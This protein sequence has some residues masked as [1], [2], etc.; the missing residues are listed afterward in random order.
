MQY[1]Y[2][3]TGNAN[4]A[5]IYGATFIENNPGWATIDVDPD[6]LYQHVLIGDSTT[7]TITIHN[8]GDTDLQ[9][10]IAAS[11]SQRIASD[12][13]IYLTTADQGPNISLE[14]GPGVQDP[15]YELNLERL[16]SRPS[17][18]DGDL[19]VLLM[20]NNTSNN[21]YFAGQIEPYVENMDFASWDIDQTPELTYLQ[22]FDVILLQENGLTGNSAN[23]GDI[24]AEYV[25][26]GGN[27]ILS[28]FYWQDRTD[29][30]FGTQGWGELELY[31]PLYGDACDYA[32]QDLGT[33]LDHPMTEGIDE[34]NCYYRGGPTILRDDATAVAWWSDGDP[35][36]AYNQPGGVI[37][38]ITIFP[39]HGVYSSFSGDFYELF[40]N[41]IYWTANASP[42]WL[43]TDIVSGTVAPGA[44][45]DI[46]VSL[47]ASELDTGY[48]TAQLVLN[49]NDPIDPSVLIPV[50]LEVYML[51]PDIA[52]A[53]DSLSEELYIGDSSVQTLMIYN[54]GEADLDWNA[55]TLFLELPTRSPRY[56]LV[57]YS[58]N[59]KI[60]NELHSIQNRV[61]GEE[62][63]VLPDTRTDWLNLSVQ[64]GTILVG[65]SELID[66]IFDASAIDEGDFSA[67]I[68]VISNDEDES[69]IDI[70]VTLIANTPYPDISVTPGSLD[71]NLFLGDSSLQ[72]LII[73][74]NGLADLNWNLNIL[75]YG[76]DNNESYVFT[77]CGSEG[78]FGPSQEDCDGEYEGT[79]LADV[80]VVTEG[81]QEWTVPQNGLYTIEALG[82]KGG[83]ASNG[84]GYAGGLG[85]RMVGAFDLTEGEIINILVGQIGGSEQEGAG[86]GGSFVTDLNNNPIIVAGAGGGA[87]GAGNGLGL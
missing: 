73:S 66:V 63:V 68:Q 79:S 13:N 45:Q 12:N 9:W 47:N 86:G 84:G 51:F 83:D 5:T 85:A 37:T 44:S 48:Y 15:V 60:D 33:V 24:L 65:E 67:V 76:R 71:D 17:G 28:T 50:G 49:S 8:T 18:R 19:Q 61:G 46:I 62:M 81:V 40:S 31:D 3:H 20:S 6:S 54:N 4:H 53:P 87:G 22:Q 59:Q 32:Y 7:Q 80:V 16:G 82:A 14:D 29:G 55:T 43:S 42:G 1:I 38:A 21:D 41:A 30:G 27:L 57:S 23:I 75:D 11:N 26:D 25:L 56:E 2:D 70:P 78:T 74:N 39:A 35:L 69:Q 77:N 64:S 34:L 72:S 58:D 36:I 10:E 52:I